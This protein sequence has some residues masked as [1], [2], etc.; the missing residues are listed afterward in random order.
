MFKK[1]LLMISI[2]LIL[3]ACN[4]TK[5]KPWQ[6]GYLA[7]PIMSDAQGLSVPLD[8]H[9]FTSKEASSGGSGVAAGGCGCN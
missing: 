3:S 5:V 1:A 6:R 9:T 4:M 8:T 7:Q 2:S